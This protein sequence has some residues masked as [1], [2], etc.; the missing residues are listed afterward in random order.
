MEKYIFTKTELQELFDHAFHEGAY[1]ETGGWAKG[2]ERPTIDEWLK[3]KNI[4]PNTPV[5]KAVCDKCKGELKNHNGY[6]FCKD[7]KCGTIYE[8]TVL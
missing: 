6:I 2:R 3:A 7:E 1:W 8:Q 4:S 5:I